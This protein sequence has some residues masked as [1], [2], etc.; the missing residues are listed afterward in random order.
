MGTFYV[1]CDA[2]NFPA[3]R[4]LLWINYVFV[5]SHQELGRKLLEVA[6]GGRTEEVIALL[7]QGAYIEATGDWV[8]HVL[9]F[10][11]SYIHTWA[12]AYPL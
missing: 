5:P 7:D 3:L 1:A 4:V 12:Y 6:R 11:S 9:Y 10:K 2:F 8:R